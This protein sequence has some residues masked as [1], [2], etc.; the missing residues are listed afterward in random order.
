MDG[1]KEQHLWNIFYHFKIDEDTMSVLRSQSKCLA[2]MSKNLDAWKASP[3]S[4]FLFMCSQHTLLKLHQYWSFYADSERLSDAERMLQDY[5]RM[6]K[7]IDLNLSTSRSAG[8]FSTFAALAL[9]QHFSNYW[10]TG[11]VFRKHSDLSR[12]VLPNPTFFYSLVGEG[13]CVHYGT[14]PLGGFHLAEAYAHASSP[15]KVTEA[16]LI[17]VAMTQFRQWCAAFRVAV[18]ADSV[19]LRVFAGDAIAFCHALRDAQM[20]SCNSYLYTSAWCGT[21]LVLDGGEYANSRAPSRFDVID[22]SNILDH[23]GLLNVL[24]AASPLLRQSLSCLYTEGLLAQNGTGDP[25][26]GLQQQLCASIPTISLLFGII[27]SACLTNFTTSSNVHELMMQPANQF[28]ERTLWRSPTAVGA[29]CLDPLPIPSFGTAQLA[30]ILFDIY[31]N[32]FKEM[33]DIGLKMQALTNPQAARTSL[34]GLLHYNRCTFA[35]LLGLVKSRVIVDWQTMMEHLYDLLDIDRSLILNSN[36]HQELYCQLFIRGIYC[37]DALRIEDTSSVTSRIGKAKIYQQW[38]TI[39]PVVCLVLL[40]PREKIQVL[41]ALHAADR[42]GTPILE[43]SLY[44]STS[45]NIFSSINITFGTFTLHGTGENATVLINEDSTGFDGR[46]PLIISAWVPAFNLTLPGR[47]NVT[48]SLAATPAL[49]PELMRELGPRLALFTASLFDRNFVHVVSGRPHFPAELESMHSVAPSPP[50]KQHP[51]VFVDTTSGIWTLKRKWDASKGT[52]QEALSNRATVI[53]SIQT[54][55]CS[56]RLQ[57]GSGVC[58]TVLYPAPID[59]GRVKLRIAR[60][61][62]FVE[63]SQYYSQRIRLISYNTRSLFRSTGHHLM[64][65]ILLPVVPP[66][67]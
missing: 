1:H 18:K 15:E 4:K 48:L 19:R 13:W 25:V 61:S 53:Q 28:H 34:Q 50:N 55:P 54:S 49:A 27:P 5:R 30:K 31:Y 46:S 64:K 12:A 40:V 39:P 37:V 11:T 62:G 38:N 42:L 6:H 41:E 14:D 22:T 9:E 29:K 45:H 36:Y 7:Q 20:V 32:M 56:V 57:I 10:K 52:N 17:K 33:E 2:D 24:I 60:T 35:A 43:L 58:A 59:N 63:V 66:Y 47:A 65:E 21:L 26:T 3:Y 44:V 8:F 51:P 67:I 16:D 23:I